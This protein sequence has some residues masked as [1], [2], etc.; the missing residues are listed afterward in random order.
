MITLLFILTST[1]TLSNSITFLA[2]ERITPSTKATPTGDPNFEVI[3]PFANQH[4]SD[5]FTNPFLMCDEWGQVTKQLGK[6]AMD[7][8]SPQVTGKRHV[9]WHPHRGF[10]IVS[11]IKEGRGSHADSMGNVEIVRPGGIQWMRTGSGV[12]HAEGGGNPEG[13]AKHGFQLWINLPASMKMSEPDYGTVQPEDIPE[14]DYTTIGGGLLRYY[15]GAFKNSASFNDRNDFTIIDVEV[16]SNATQIVSIPIQFERI[17][18]YVYRGHGTVSGKKVPSQKAAV[19]TI[20]ALEVDTILDLD[21][22]SD[23]YQHVENDIFANVATMELKAGTEGYAVMIFAAIPMNEPIAW[24]GPIVMNKNSEIQ[25]AY[26][27]LRAGTFLK[28]RV[29]YDY[30]AKALTKRE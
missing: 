3:R 19:M 6:P 9:G 20:G 7:P 11:V 15:A 22:S 14:E 5:T 12:E 23:P 18:V 4:L 27:E 29:D 1:F 21:S 24:R 10:D 25:T 8:G 26:K 13:A 2:V 30:K 28:K 16:P 17:I